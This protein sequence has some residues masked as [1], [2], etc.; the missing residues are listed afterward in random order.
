L[1]NKRALEGDKAGV[2]QMFD[3][4]FGTATTTKS[5]EQI[6]KE[7][8]LIAGRWSVSKNGGSVRFLKK[9]ETK[10]LELLSEVLFHPAWK[11]EEFDLAMSQ[12]KTALSSLGDDAGQINQRVSDVLTYGSAFPDGEIETEATLTTITLSDLNAL[13]AT[14][15]APNVARLVIVG[16]ITV[17]EAKATAEKYFGSWKKKDVPVAKYII[18]T[19]PKENKVAFVSKPGAAQTMIDVSYPVKYNPA[20]PDVLTASVMGQILG[21]SGTGHLF[22]NL[23][24]KHS[25]TYGVYAHLSSGE[26][27]GRFNISSGRGAASVKATA[28]DSSVYEILYEL[29]RIIEEPVTEAELAAAKTYVAG[30]FSRMLENSSNIANFALNIDKYGLPKDYYKTYLTRLEAITVQDIQAA[31]KKYIQPKNALIVVTGDPGLKE[32]LTQFA[33]DGKVYEYDYNA[34]PVK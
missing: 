6:N 11:Q 1:D 26:L 7:F 15:F 21:G 3:L 28:T 22:M 23:R 19:A 34:N 10:A 30:S 31:A 20:E 5:K 14:Y 29:N 17:Q 18:P 12:Y 2:G 25:Y 33:A 9:Y 32:S 24:E 4:V 16:N 13:Y 8:D 27:I